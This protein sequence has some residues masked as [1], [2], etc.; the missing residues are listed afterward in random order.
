MKAVLGMIRR[1]RDE[2]VSRA[3]LARFDDRLL[4]DL[5]IVRGDIPRIVRRLK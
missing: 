4:D 2:S 1:W 3:Q 5:G